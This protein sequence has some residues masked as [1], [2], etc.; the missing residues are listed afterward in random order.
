MKAVMDI[1][2]FYKDNNAGGQ[3]D[4]I[5]HKFDNARSPEMQQRD[6]RPSQSY[7]N[8][9]QGGSHSPGPGA[10]I[11]PPASPRFPSN[12]ESSFENPR[13]APTPPSQRS[14][15]PGSAGFRISGSQQSGNVNGTY[16]A[17]RP[18]PRPPGGATTAP[19][20][21]PQRIAPAA[22]PSSARDNATFYRPS[23]QENAN[24]KNT[25]AYPT[26]PESTSA[27]L[28]R[29]R[30]HTTGTSPPPVEAGHHHGGGS[31]YPYGDREV[32]QQTLLK[33]DMRGQPQG[34]GRSQSYK[35]QSAYSPASNAVQ[36]PAQV[37]P[38]PTQPSR[39][40]GAPTPRPRHRN[41]E[42]G[43]AEII[44]RLNEI[45]TPGDPR[46]MYFNLSTIGKGASGAVYTAYESGTNRC[47]AIKQMNLKQQ[48]KKDLIVNEI[49]VMR[50]SKHK[51]IVNFLDSY[52][53]GGDLWVIMEYMEGGSLTDV[54][55]FNMMS[56]ALIAAVCREV[57]SQSITYLRNV[58]NRIRHSKAYSICIHDM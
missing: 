32:E 15:G 4:K 34:L 37:I 40:E 7:S 5:F 1:V 22:P 28:Y 25:Y 51:N 18:A 55:T 36:P 42:V 2:A 30:A 24:G 35:Q 26:I 6:R 20:F 3:E 41:R 17:H 29:E 19:Q 54:V 21:V 46:Q 50:G 27:S 14:S 10:Y 38:Q 53:V 43:S 16:F 23:T 13:A 31:V 39:A 45:C 12:H 49:I 9:S 58:T 56:E 57:S 48:P 33:V 52:L 8:S 11:S 44:A 47:V